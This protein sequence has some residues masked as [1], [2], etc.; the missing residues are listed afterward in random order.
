MFLNHI[1]HEL[2]LDSRIQLHVVFMIKTVKCKNFTRLEK[3][4]W[5]C[6][7]LNRQTVS[8]GGTN[9]VFRGVFSNTVRRAASVWTVHLCV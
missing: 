3:E 7:T 4:H 9:Q 2:V 6:F 8:S 1:N 5:M